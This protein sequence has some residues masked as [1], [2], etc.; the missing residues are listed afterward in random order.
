ML[1]APVIHHFAEEQVP[2]GSGSAVHLAHQVGARDNVQDGAIPGEVAHVT[3]LVTSE[4]VQWGSFATLV[5]EVTDSATRT[6]TEVI[7]VL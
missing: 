1:A 6:A 7:F 4:M 3:T 2:A 5:S